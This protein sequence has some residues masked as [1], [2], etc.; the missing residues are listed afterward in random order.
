MKITYTLTFPNELTFK[1]YHHLNNY[2]WKNQKKSWFP[3]LHP[4]RRKIKVGARLPHLQPN[5]FNISKSSLSVLKK[6]TNQSKNP[7]KIV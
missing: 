1:A 5:T 3:H 2:I 4:K 6:K 7:K